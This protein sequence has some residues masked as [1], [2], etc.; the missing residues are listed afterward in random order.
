MVTLLGLLSNLTP[1]A[2]L[3]GVALGVSAIGLIILAR[4]MPRKTDKGS[5]AA[6]ALEGLQNLPRQHRPVRQTWR[7]R[8]RSGIATC[9]TPSPLASTSSTFASSRNVDAPAPGWYIPSPS[10][11]GGYR[12]RLLRHAGPT[13]RC[14]GLYPD[15]RHGRYGRWV[16]VG[17]WAAAWAMSRPAAR[18]SDMSRGMGGSLTAMSAGLG[19]MLAGASTTMTSRPASTSSSGGGWSGGRG[20]L[21]RA[22]A[23]L[24]AAA[25]AAGG[26][27]FS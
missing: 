18:L 21:L 10:A 14:A 24:A 1:L 25:A 8:S 17:A 19:T 26:G 6:V 16:P 2:A 11:Y 7:R 13:P 5:E 4:F 3:P 9:P 20:R 22:A 27:G 15:G 23:A 12:R